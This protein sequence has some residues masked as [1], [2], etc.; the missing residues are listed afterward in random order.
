[1][2]ANTTE[3]TQA[4]A[5]IAPAAES[6]SSPGVPKKITNAQTVC[7]EKNEKGKLCNGHLKQIRTGGEEALEHLRG[8]D[9]LFKCQFCGTLYMGPPLGHVRDPYKQERFVEKELTAIL[10][11]AGGTLPAIVKNEKGAYVLAEAKAAHAPAK[12]A[13][14]AKPTTETATQNAGPIAPTKVVEQPATAAAQTPAAKPATESGT[15]TGYVPPPAPGPVPGETPEQKLARLKA[16]VAEAK[17]RKA[18]AEAAAEA[19][20]QPAP[21]PSTQPVAQTQPAA[22]NTSGTDS[23]AQADEHRP[24]AEAQAATGQ[25]SAVPLN[26]SAANASPA[27]LEAQADSHGTPGRAAFDTGPVAGETH[28]QKIARLRLVVNAARELAGKPPKY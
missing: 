4:S 10:Q 16:I 17:R 15:V 26:P 28:E 25:A 24:A 21:A 18:A 3:T 22:A 7:N 2:S 6:P 11:A 13:A 12:P 19:G 1:M 5:S 8:D 9:V 14:A 20:D 27:A 23:S